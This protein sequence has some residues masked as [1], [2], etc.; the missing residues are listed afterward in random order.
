MV[1]VIR[2]ANEAG[3]RVAPQA[4]GHN[5][6]PLGNLAETVLV[7]MERMRAVEIRPE[8]MVARA[9][10]GCVWEDVVVPAADAGYAVLHGSSPDVGVAG[11]MLGGGVGWLA[12]KHG[13]ATNSL[14]AVELVTPAG[15]FVRAD[16]STTPC[17]SGRCAVAEGTSAS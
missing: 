6:P 12:R 4:T 5:A 3:L 14:T 16:P 10:A 1:A 2:Y 11:Y 17:C 13:L 9:E 7:K 15:E 8:A